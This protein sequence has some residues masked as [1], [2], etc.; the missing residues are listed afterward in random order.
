MNQPFDPGLQAER[1][2]L[3]W[4]RTCL[5]LLTGS[6]IAAR[7]LPELFGPWS[8][9]A[10]L[11]GVVCAAIL[12]ASVHRRYQRQHRGLN[13]EGDLFPLADGRPVAAL[14]TVA[15]AAALISVGAVVFTVLI[16]DRG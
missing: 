12:L 4:R 15:F 10:G 8:A 16:L 11:A 3:A 13:G 14:A 6:L 2:A 1:T 9:L 5:A 7:I